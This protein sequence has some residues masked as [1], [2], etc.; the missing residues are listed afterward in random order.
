MAKTYLHSS[1]EKNVADK[2]EPQRN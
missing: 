2:A 1:A